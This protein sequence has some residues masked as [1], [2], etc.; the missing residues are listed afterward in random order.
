MNAE[1]FFAT[2]AQGHKAFSRQ[3]SLPSD[4]SDGLNNSHLALA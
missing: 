1:Y 4:L 3:H 2:K